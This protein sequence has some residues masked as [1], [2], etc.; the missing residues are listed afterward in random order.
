MSIELFN[1]DFGRYGYYGFV[2]FTIDTPMFSRSL[3]GISFATPFFIFIQILFFNIN[4]E[5]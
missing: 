1:I 5:L 4:I 3:F 2:I